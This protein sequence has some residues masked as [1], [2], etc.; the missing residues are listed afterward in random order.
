MRQKI[1]ELIL[2]LQAIAKDFRITELKI[3][4][5]TKSILKVRL[6]VSEDIF[7][8]I[9]VNLKRPKI[10]YALIINDSRIFG[11]D[12]LFEEWHLHPFES[13]GKHDVSEKAKQPVAIEDFVEEALFI[14]SEKLKII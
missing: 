14:L 13:P 9:Y 5:K 12:Y 1:E 3:I 4:E 11:K 7:I 8:Q 10:S 6:F 2:Q